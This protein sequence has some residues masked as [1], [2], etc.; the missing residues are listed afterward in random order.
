MSEKLTSSTCRSSGAVWKSRWPSWALVPNKPTV[1]VN[2]KQHFNNNKLHILPSDIQPWQSDSDQGG[3]LQKRWSRVSSLADQAVIRHGI[4]HQ[5]LQQ[6]KLVT[7]LMCET[8]KPY[9]RVVLIYRLLTD[10]FDKFMLVILVPYCALLD[11]ESFIHVDIIPLLVC[12]FVCGTHVF[13][14]MEQR[15]TWLD[16][17]D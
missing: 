15:S 16:L 12:K 2:A 8:D 7:Q 14:W 4:T 5:S 11:Y 9:M 17:T 13:L 10:Y 1:S 3:L 6:G